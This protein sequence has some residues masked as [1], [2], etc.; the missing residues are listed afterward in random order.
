MRKLRVALTIALP[1]IACAWLLAHTVRGSSQPYSSGPISP[2]HS[3]FGN[4]CEACHVS[5]KSLLG[6]VSFER[7]V[8]DRACQDCH[9][10]PVHQASETFTPKCADCHTEHVGHDGLMGISDKQCVQCHS[11]LH[12][13]N[14]TP[15]FEPVVKTFL[16]DH[17]EF[18]PLRKPH[19]PGTIALNH[20]AH[21]RTGIRGP[22]GEVQMQCQDCHRP[23]AEA[24][25]SWAYSLSS[26]GGLA[27]AGE[28]LNAQLI[29]TSLDPLPPS[30]GRAHMTPIKYDLQCAACHQLQFDERIAE[31]VPHGKP[32]IIHDFVTQKYRQYLNLHPNAWR[33][34]PR[35]VR[36]I[37]GL[38]PPP[39]AH[40]PEEW[41]SLQ[42]AQAEM[43]LWR[44]NCK[45]CHTIDS[46]A[47]KLQI[48]AASITVRWLPNSTFNHY[49][50]QAVS[51]DSC[52]SQ[53]R[54][55]KATSDVLIPSIEICRKCHNAE[56][57][58][59]G[60][61][62]DNCSLCHQ[63]H[64]WNRQQPGLKG[65]F[66]IDQLLTGKLSAPAAQ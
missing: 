43:L 21:L 8:T 44:K 15:R 30:T 63:Y 64:D 9:N 11:D 26:V 39:P 34:T 25:Q 57:S 10:S 48:R 58:V 61:A 18:K 50:H 1:V 27:S 52:H 14:G 23:A 12:V 22:K 45:L 33:E 40:S 7:H 3:V 5:S 13:K 16:H 65:K 47:G 24:T 20:E 41:V 66:T 2:A 4:N 29:P 51:C 17:P 42:T 6:H 49:A 28:Q 46:V 37:P 53:S 56:P 38:E 59:V 60:A 19:D 32:E 31:L 54:T 55:S 36:R 62:G 35:A